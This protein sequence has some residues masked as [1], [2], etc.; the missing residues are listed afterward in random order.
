MKMI[1]KLSRKANIDGTI[2]PSACHNA[3]TLSISTD[4]EMPISMINRVIA[5]AKTPSQKASRRTLGF[6]SAIPLSIGRLRRPE[7]AG[8][9]GFATDRRGS[10]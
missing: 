1:V 9:G 7:T 5:M 2:S 10:P 8:A 3:L 4:G 6:A